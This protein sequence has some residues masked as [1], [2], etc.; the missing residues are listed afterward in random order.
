[1]I[2][3][4]SHPDC[5]LCP[6]LCRP[7]LG[8][9]GYSITQDGRVWSDKTH[10]FLAGAKKCG[11]RIVLLRKEGKPHFKRVHRLVLETFVGPC[12]EE[13]ECRHLNGRRADNRLE[14]LVWGTRSENT[15]DAVRH[16]TLAD[17]RRRVLTA[18]LVRRMQSESLS[19]RNL[20][21]KYHVGKTTAWRVR[22]GRVVL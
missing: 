19:T 5:R 20:A 12:P 9:P 13:M 4:L 8:Y 6:L 16:G 11:Y 2:E 7:I 17:N 21:R 10:R 15:K 18:A 22:A 14:N 1:M 3:F